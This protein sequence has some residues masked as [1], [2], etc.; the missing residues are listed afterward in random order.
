MNVFGTKL[1]AREIHTKAKLGSLECTGRDIFVHFPADL[2]RPNQETRTTPGEENWSDTVYAHGTVRRPPITFRVGRTAPT[3]EIWAGIDS[4]KIR[5]NVQIFR[6]PRN[7]FLL[8]PRNFVYFLK[9]TPFF[10]VYL[11]SW[12][13]PLNSYGDCCKN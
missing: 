3:T 2:I 1:D 6:I 7:F 8:R 9:H 12:S 11:K 10:K 5:A 13:I 4:L